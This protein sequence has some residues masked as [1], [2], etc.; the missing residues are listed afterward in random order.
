MHQVCMANPFTAEEQFYSRYDWCLNPILSVRELIH[1]FEQELDAFPASD[2]WQREEMKINLY[3]F[4][5]A[6]ACTADDYFNQRLVDFAPLYSRL[7]HLRTL[8]G[9]VEWAL[10]TSALLLRIPIN[11]R[12]WRWRKR[13]NLCIEEVCS[14]LLAQV[15]HSSGFEFGESESRVRRATVP[16]AGLPKRLL[17]WRMRLPEAFR[18]QDFTHQDVI[19]LIQ[20][21]RTSSVQNDR[22]ITII[23]LRTAGSYFAP[24]MAAYL[25]RSKFTK[26]S[27]FSIRPKNGI[28]DRKS[29]V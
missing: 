3:L 17:N 26:V 1:R 21:F 4:A 23:G 2:G 8:L 9:P 22:P 16:S 12:A 24:L 10:N 14:L 7:P 25:K 19:S 28:S 29:V 27:W 15:P 5:C 11:W 13:W 18:R 20:R 6:I